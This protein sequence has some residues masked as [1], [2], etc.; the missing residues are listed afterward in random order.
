MK[1]NHFIEV[2]HSQKQKTGQ[3]I[4]GDVFLSKKMAKGDRVVSVLAD[5]LGS[6]IKACVP[7]SLTARMALEYVTGHIEIRRAAEIILNAMPVCPQRKISYSTFSVVDADINGMAYVIEHGNPPFIL[8]RGNQAIS[9]PHN[10][11]RQP[12]WHNREINFSEFETQIGDRI[13]LLSDGV[14]QSGIGSEKY[15]LGWGEENLIHFIQNMIEENPEISARKLSQFIANRAL[16]NDGGLAGDDITCGVVY[17]RKPRHLILLTGAPYS[18]KKDSEYAHRLDVSD[19]M[20]VICGGTT[21]NIISRELQRN[22]TMDL[23][24]VDPEIPNTSNMDGVDLVTE[25]CITLG[26]VLE[27]FESGN[28]DQRKNGA[29]RLA[30]LLLQSDVIDFLVGTKINEAHQN[31]NIPVELDIRRNIIKQIMKILEEKYLKQTSIEY[32]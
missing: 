9:V 30:N 27:I 7:A 3:N 1:T 15:P 2:G 23:S 16:M 29:T 6:G 13:I 20:K 8:I 28:F 14:S 22:V 11:L 17:F 12:K 10:V 25:G 32:F 24:V 19:G 31:P 21:A 18:P 5:G 26:K 4:A